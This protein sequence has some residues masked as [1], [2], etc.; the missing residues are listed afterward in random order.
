MS[1]KP[2]Q[3]RRE[4]IEQKN[5]ILLAVSAFKKNQEIRSICEAAR[6]YNIHKRTLRRQLNRITSRS[7]IRANNYKLTQNKKDLLVQ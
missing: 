4:S 1:P 3:N 6:I 2:R 5:R 7:E